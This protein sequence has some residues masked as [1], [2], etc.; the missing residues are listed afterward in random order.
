DVKASDVASFR[1]TFGLTGGSYT[2]INN[3]SDPG[4]CTSTASGALCTLDDQIENALDVE[5]AGATAAKAAVKL[6]V[7]NQTNSND[8][9]YLSAKY[10]I[11]NNVAKIINVSYGLCELGMGTAG[12]AL[13]NNLWQSAATAGISVFVATGDSGSPAC[14]QGQASQ[15]PYGAQFG[16]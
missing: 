12:N 15:G 3:G 10:A 16:L 1:S 13:Y 5:W 14:D 2:Q 8:A 11:D 6:I 7:T 9:I 4:N